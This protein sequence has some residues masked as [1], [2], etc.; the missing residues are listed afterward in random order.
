MNILSGKRAQYWFVIREL[1]GREIKRK[2]S[3]SKLGIIW[4]VLNPLLTMAVLSAVFTQ[5]FAR[6]ID[7]FPIYYLCGYLIWVLFTGAT[8]SAMTALVDNRMMLI[9]VKFPMQIF[10]LARVYTAFV[11]FLYSLIAFGAI[12]IVFAG[13]EKYRIIPGVTW[14]FMPVII[15]FLILFAVGIGYILATAYVFFGDIKHLYGVLTTLWMYLSAI[16]YPIDSLGPFITRV[17]QINPVFNYIDGM[18]HLVLYNQLPP[19]PEI[20]RMIACGVVSYFIGRQIFLSN[21]NKIMQK[22]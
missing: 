1:T 21:K 10:M 5:L 13:T 18:R 4:S 19:G 8:N 22:L 14:F 15:V 3:G 17:I 9:K 6:S 2:Y 16:F 12:L 11:N 20:I 7:N